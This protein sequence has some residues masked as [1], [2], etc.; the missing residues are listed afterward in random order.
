MYCI[1]CG[2]KL[3]DTEKKCPLCGTV[4]YHPE[5]KQNMARP[6]YPSNKMP[7]RTSGTKAIS[8]A[9]IILFFIP[10]LICWFSD[11]QMNGSL[12]WF[13]YVA[14][15][16]AVTYTVV[17]LPLWFHKPNPV[18]FMPCNFLVIGLYLLYINCATGGE[19]F[20][21]FAFP[22]VGGVGLITCAVVT[23]FYYLHRGKLYIAG[24]AFMVLGIFMLVIEFLMCRTFSLRFVGWS[25][26]PLIALML[27]GGLLIYLAINRIAREMIERKLFF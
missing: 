6:L 5:I 4:V 7:K 3:S 15:A 10:L 12:D 22:V 16:L 25:V 11:L 18:I 17:A 19:W 23:L 20:L 21:S 26:Y 27:L 9:M 24:G 13:G 1:N 8:G 2:V 14:G